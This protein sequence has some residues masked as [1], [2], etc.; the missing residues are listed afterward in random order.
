MPLAEQGGPFNL[1]SV[2]FML[3]LMF[4]VWLLLLRSR[5]YLARRDDSP[6]VRIE[7]PAPDKPLPPGGAPEAVSRWEVHLHE[8]A[9]ELSAQLDSK[10]VALQQLVREADRA[11]ARLE[12]ALDA[13][14][15][16]G[17]PART[18]DA[19]DEAQAGEPLHRSPLTTHSCNDAAQRRHEE[20]YLLA[21]YG[22]EP[23]EIARRVGMPV[24]EVHLILSL[25][26]K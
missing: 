3:A 24:G 7:R 4:T 9:R 12:K 21:D 25:R 19:A 11:A 15:S 6:I 2:V 13:A 10:M 23:L 16:A 26:P 8:T 22:H 1:A 5:R 17:G 14:N 20:I 18:L